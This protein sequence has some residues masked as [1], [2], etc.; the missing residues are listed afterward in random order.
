MYIRVYTDK[1]MVNKDVQGNIR[2]NSD[3]KARLQLLGYST[4]D[5]WEIGAE[6]VESFNLTGE[7]KMRKDLEKIRKEKQDCQNKELFLEKKLLE[8]NEKKE[9][10]EKVETEAK[11]IKD[12]SCSNCGR[13]FEE[14]EKRFKFDGKQL[15]RVCFISYA[16]KMRGKLEKQIAPDDVKKKVS[17]QTPPS[18]K[19]ELACCGFCNGEFEEEELYFL[20][21]GKMICSGCW[22]S[23]QTK[24][25][26][27]KKKEEK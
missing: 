7:S 13:E 26:P 17:P 22:E 5:L 19:K 12:N 24:P 27:I 14:K 2:L 20:R 3:R 25:L 1:N 16:G 8:L 10:K 4:T 23:T 9:A 18:K 6:L 11:F 15:C 21:K